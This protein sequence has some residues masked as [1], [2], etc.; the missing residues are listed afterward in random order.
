M[1]PYVTGSVIDL[2]VFYRVGSAN[3]DLSGLGLDLS[4]GFSSADL[5]WNA[6]HG[7]YTQSCPYL[8][9]DC[10]ETEL[11]PYDA[12]SASF[13]SGSRIGPALGI[14]VDARAGAFVIGLNATYRALYFEGSAAPL[15]KESDPVHTVS[16]FFHLG[17][18]FAL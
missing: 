8:S 2:M 7:A 18:G 6:G 4:V 11:S 13:R 5:T 17:F 15:A 9:L 10:R 16:L 12:S 3:R 14:G 1:T